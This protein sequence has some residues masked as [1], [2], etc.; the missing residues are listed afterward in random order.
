MST[1]IAAQVAL[2]QGHI[3][4]PGQRRPARTRRRTGHYVRPGPKMPT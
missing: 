2:I 4:Q 3:Q 1:P